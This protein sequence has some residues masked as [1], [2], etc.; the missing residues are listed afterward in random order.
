MFKLLKYM[1]LVALFKDVSASYQEETGAGRPFYLSRRFIGAVIALAG[2]AATIAFGITIDATVLNQLTDNL[3][4]G[5]SAIVVLYG[6]ILTIVG[7]FKA[8]KNG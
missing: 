6:V 1:P 7:A 2:G 3:E 8:K 5:I 4:K